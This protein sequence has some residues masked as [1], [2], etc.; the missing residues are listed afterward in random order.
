MNAARDH[1]QRAQRLEA[2]GKGDA[3][4]QENWDTVKQLSTSAVV[5]ATTALESVINEFYLDAMAENSFAVGPIGPNALQTLRVLW[6]ELERRRVSILGKYDC[7]LTTCGKTPISKGEGVGQQAEGLIKLRNAIVHF[8]PEWSGE[9]REHKKLEERLAPMFPSCDLAEQSSGSMSWF[10]FRCLGAGCAVWAVD[11]AQS[12]VSEFCDRL[13]LP[14][15][16]K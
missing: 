4:P 16:L 14:E 13:G 11:T 1:S 6:P 9:R 8:K 7:A 5:M 3:W 2:A 12:F 10:P 15:R